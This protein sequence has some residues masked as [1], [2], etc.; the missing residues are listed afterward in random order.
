M[1]LNIKM[2]K[3]HSAFGMITI[4]LTIIMAFT[5]LDLKYNFIADSGIYR[6]VH[7]NISPVFTIFLVVLAITGCYLYF[8]PYLMRRKL[9]KQPQE[10]K[11]E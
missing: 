2:R 10:K 5:G 4:L 9:K 3:I 11:E 7:N 1:A 6:F 8:Y